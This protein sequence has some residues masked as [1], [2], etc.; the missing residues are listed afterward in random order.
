MRAAVI[1]FICSFFVPITSI[2]QELTAE[3]YLKS[4]QNLVGTVQKESDLTLSQSIKFKARDTGLSK[5]YQPA[6]VFRLILPEEEIIYESVRTTTAKLEQPIERLAKVLV[7]GDIQLFKL[8]L[9]IE[10]KEI[11]KLS[12]NNFIFLIRKDNQLS[13]L[14][15]IELTRYRIKNPEVDKGYVQTYGIKEEYIGILKNVFKTCPSLFSKIDNTK[16][17]AEDIISVIEA[18]QK[19]CASQPL[20]ITIQEQSVKEVRK[21]ISVGYRHLLTGGVDGKFSFAA[22][23]FWDS[24]DPER[25]KRFSFLTGA[26]YQYFSGSEFFRNNEEDLEFHLIV[27]PVQTTFRIYQNTKSK[28]YLFFGSNF[29]LR[30]PDRFGRYSVL[31]DLDGGLGSYLGNYRL[32]L[33]WQQDFLTNTDPNGYLAIEFGYMF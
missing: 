22:G 19:R 3:L 24:F 11:I 4:G 27:I 5:T 25:S 30:S 14:E 7:D 16:F 13:R 32:H 33:S 17:K 1:F 29:K 31:L 28:I 26:E 15:R 6:E 8:Q 9:Q 18:Y 2:A 10:E 23:F 12:N 21:G 20:S